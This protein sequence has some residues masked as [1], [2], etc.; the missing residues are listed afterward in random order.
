MIT[1]PTLQGFFPGSQADVLWEV[2]GNTV[3]C[4]IGRATRSHTLSSNKFSTAVAQFAI[5][6]WRYA[7]NPSFTLSS[8]LSPLVNGAPFALATQG[9]QHSEVFTVH[10]FRPLSAYSKCISCPHC[11]QPRCNTACATPQTWRE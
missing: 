9:V 10:S 5:G 4:T 6:G 1:I 3:S 7:Y 8:W 11:L 2:T